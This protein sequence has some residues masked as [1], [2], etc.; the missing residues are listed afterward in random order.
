MRAIDVH[1]H[2][3]TAQ[4]SYERRWGKEVAEFLPKYYRI[5]EKIRSDEKWPKISGL[6]T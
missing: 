4:F 1:V 6:L 5:Q 3:S 2:P